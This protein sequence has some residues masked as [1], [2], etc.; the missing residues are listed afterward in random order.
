MFQDQCWTNSSL[1]NVH[2]RI[3][4]STWTIL[5][6]LNNERI[7]HHQIHYS[8]LV[9]VSIEVKFAI[10]LKACSIKFGEM[11]FIVWWST[12]TLETER[13]L[14]ATTLTDTRNNKDLCS[15]GEFIQRNSVSHPLDKS[16]PG[17]TLFYPPIHCSQAKHSRKS[18]GA[19][20]HLTGH[21]GPATQTRTEGRLGNLS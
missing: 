2:I 14:M 17:F 10:L 21:S 15:S 13:S 8:L 6:Q 4:L 11:L 18:F 7:N 1:G 20:V 16:F 3:I 19:L 9:S 12:P 5:H